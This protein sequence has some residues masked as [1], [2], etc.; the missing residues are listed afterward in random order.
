[1]TWIGLI[2]M[3]IAFSVSWYKFSK[4]FEIRS[5][6]AGKSDI[7][8]YYSNGYDLKISSP[9]GL[10]YLHEKLKALKKYSKKEQTLLGFTFLLWIFSVPIISK[11]NIKDEDIFYVINAAWFIIVMTSFEFFDILKET[12]IKSAYLVIRQDE[13]NRILNDNKLSDE[14]KIYLIKNR[15]N[16]YISD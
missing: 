1:M 10:N 2:M 15:R 4:I 8:H 12:I 9:L 16:T 11:A 14:S 7:S 3:I 5:Y 13:E 6:I